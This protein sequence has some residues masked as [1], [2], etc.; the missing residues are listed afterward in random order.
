MRTKNI[1][2]VSMRIKHAV[3]PALSILVLL[4]AIVSVVAVLRAPFPLKVSLGAPTAY[5][6]IY[7]HVPIAWASYL[8]FGLASLFALVFLIKGNKK[9]D[10]FSYNL[11]LLAVIFGALTLVTGSIWAKESWG[12]MWNWDPRETGVLLLFL[13]YLIY[14][15]LRSSISDVDKASR[16]SSIYLAA[17]FS[18]VPLSFLAAQIQS[19]LHPQPE[20]TSA[21]FSIPEV[22]KYFVTKNIL[23]TLNSILFAASFIGFKRGWFKQVPKYILYTG[24]IVIIIGFVGSL[25]ILYPYFTS[26][27][28]RVLSATVDSSGKI[29][30]IELVSGGKITCNPPC[31]SPIVPSLDQEGNPTIISHFITYSNG[32]IKAVTYWGVGINLLLYLL[33]VSGLLIYLYRKSIGKKIVESGV[34]G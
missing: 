33:T 32:A 20:Q 3:L 19:S 12:A 16:L 22:I 10:L 18:L 9:Y 7:I 5:L 13:A 11:A 23:L 2:E 1:E 4:D 30:E 28:D 27:V 15:P 17:S 29:S 25:L 14:F 21:F 31:N 8:L 34:S 6:N 26:N 24:L